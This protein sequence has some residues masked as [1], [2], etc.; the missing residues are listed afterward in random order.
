M[1]QVVEQLRQQLEGLNSRLTT[2]EGERNTLTAEVQ[3]LRA[4]AVVP[5]VS[6]P[7]P[8]AQ[9]LIETQVLGKPGSF[10]GDVTKLPD[11]S[12]KF[13]SYMC[14][15]DSRYTEMF[16]HVETS[17]VPTLNAVLE[18]K[19]VR[20]S[21]QLYH[22]LVMLCS[23]AAL[24]K[25]HNVGQS[26]GFEAWRQFS[27]QWQPRVVTRFVG[28]LMQILSFSFD[29]ELVAKVAAFERLVRDYQVQSQKT[30][31]DDIKLGV[32]LINMK[33]AK[34]KEHMIRNATR[35]DTW[36]KVKTEIV[37][38]AR[39]QEY[40]NSMPVPMQLD[41][42]PRRDKGKGKDKGKGNGKGKGKD[43]KGQFGKF[44]AA[45]SPTTA[46]PKAKAKADADKSC[47]YCGKKGHARAK[48]VS[49]A[50][51]RPV[52][53]TAIQAAGASAPD[54][55]PGCS[56]P[57]SAGFL[58]AL[59]EASAVC[60]NSR[61]DTPAAT[62]TAVCSL[63][64]HRLMIDNCAGASIFPTDYDG[65]AVFDA[66]VRPVVLETA[67]GE[68]VTA[69]GG[70]RSSFATVDGR[71]FQVRYNEGSVKFP[72]VSVSEAADQGN[73]FVF[74]P[75]T[76]AM[77]SG[78]D[79]ERVREAV[80]RGTAPVA[81]AR[82]KGVYWLDCVAGDRGDAD[83]LCA[84]KPAAKVVEAMMLT[85][86][87]RE[88]SGAASSGVVPAAQGAENPISM[89]SSEESRRVRAKKIPPTVSEQEFQLHQISHL[90]FR[91]WCDHCVRGKA[92]EDSHR[93]RH[94]PHAGVPRWG[95]DYFFE[96][97]AAE[98]ERA[99][100]VLNI[101]D[102][103][104]GCVF[105]ALAPKGEDDYALAVARETIKFTGRSK[106]VLLC[107]QERPIMKLAECMRRGQTAEIA[108]INT[109]VGSSA[110]AGGIERANY[111]VEQQCRTMRSRFEEVYPGLRVTMG[112]SIMPWLIRHA[113]WLI[114]RFQ[115]KA[116]G[117][118]AYERLRGRQYNG[119]V[120]EFG[121]LVH[122]KDPS[123]ELGKLDDRW[124][125]GLWLGK[126]MAS[127]EHYIGTPIGVRRAR[128][129]WR[130]PE[131]LRWVRAELDRLQGA[132][133][134]PT[135]RASADQPA[136]PR[137]VYIT[138]DR[139]IKYGG[140]KG[141]TACFGEART[142]NAECRARFEKL[143]A[144]ERAPAVEGTTSKNTAEAAPAGSTADAT[145]NQAAD[146]SADATPMEVTE[147][148]A[149]RSQ[150]AQKDKLEVAAAPEQASTRQR[151]VA[152]LPTLHEPAVISAPIGACLSY[153]CSSPG[154]EPEARAVQVTLDHDA[155]FYG[156]KSGKRLDPEKVRAGRQREVD[157]IGEFNVK[158][159]MLI[160]EARKR[161][162]KLVYAKWLD[163]EKPTAEDPSAV[164]SRLV[165]TEINTF[166]REDVTQATPPLKSHRA[167]ISLAATW[168]GTTGV[169]D[170]LLGRYDVRVAFFHAPSTGK[171][172]VIPPAG[173][174]PP[175][176][177]WYLLKAMY[178]T[179]EASRC[180]GSHVTDT[181]LE[182]TACPAVV[183]PM[184]FY[185]PEHGYA[186]TCHGDDFLAAG[187]ARAL[188]EVDLLLSKS[189]DTK[190]LPRIG[191]ASFGGHTSEGEHLRRLVAWTPEGFSWRASHK[192]LDDFLTL[193][194]MHAGK[195]GAEPKGAPTPAT[196]ST[197]KGLRY[198]E[199]GLTGHDKEVFPKAAG[200][201][202]YLAQDMPSVQFAT[203]E[204]LRGMSAPTQ[205]HYA[206]MK[207]I[208]HYLVKHPEE[209]WLFQYQDTP[210][211]LWVY[212]DSDWATDTETRRS[213]SCNAE[214]F[215]K[216]LL[217]FSVARQ[218]VPALSSAEA[219]FYSIVRG[220]ASGLQ[221]QQML[222]QL[223]CKPALVV[224]S[225]SSAARA[226]CGRTG[227]GKVKHLSL[228]ELWIQ[229]MVRR[230]EVVVRCVDTL[231]NWADLGTKVLDKERLDSLLR[232][233]PLRRGE[234]H[235]AT[236]G[237]A[238]MV[239]L[240]RI[241]AD[242]EQTG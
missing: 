22:V 1:E 154:G 113:S 226:I 66:S 177:C 44:Q 62:E 45:T 212:C 150:L 47:Y 236:T 181:L 220:A 229:E 231:L 175:G 107:D 204:V 3:D 59:P 117:K 221:T 171:I 4:R 156:A 67:T 138:L 61:H 135:P 98:P 143:L 159:D 31:D 20:M 202:L 128:S 222:E 29:G 86:A 17:L 23:G 176:V 133:W 174:A 43:T 109:P 41:A 35:L 30:I 92:R 15:V 146:V 14:A 155:V 190:V 105:S 71:P 147:P 121:E 166:G 94:D 96:G 194:G 170:C 183:V 27:L 24:D 21:T 101:L 118:T 5:A 112:H 207:R 60:A 124:H 108:L 2:V 184:T 208:A 114:C 140:T 85:D 102:A 200:T 178:G 122:Y 97:R 19:D 165:A 144:A 186:V 201:L 197:G 131:K 25:V 240:A 46:V 75:G 148:A 129:I 223:G 230:R 13:R 49:N 88:S 225:D 157:Q 106:I 224:L 87:G 161:G 36:E 95:M 12:F 195:S 83:L 55:V 120:V 180:W 64:K 137:G 50:E 196:K 68:P 210:E 9:S 206:K 123:K 235:R 153:L 172:A 40:I 209:V 81:L 211:E 76:Q 7:T 193:L 119:E 163:D 28:L 233:M 167:I 69:A 99:Q 219:E 132:P 151:L 56:L 8:V 158:Q 162:L 152:G 78:A 10:D 241:R 164:R 16:E 234:G 104:T 218:T 57:A 115:I 73:W 191:P 217:E 182:A 26:E 237:I 179:R 242:A 160:A 11:W 34:M 116:D 139:Q 213:M 142:H 38:I 188:D 80:Q 63:A 136:V 198:A 6:A 51:G 89:A 239:L 77:L 189:F 103:P 187:N 173:L 127:D 84:V 79:G 53:A 58:L 214:R 48:G 141:C 232:Q 145:S 238:A 72:I 199:D 18:E 185:H 203:S 42:F 52:A 192:H 130:R 65:G 169:H 82:E 37:E 32:V 90:P 33:D 134:D 125:T 54:A 205:L 215:G 216:H 227:S 126:S 228:K 93:E 39:T 149:D 70:K 110:S 168:K 74:G 100:A 111:E 91:S